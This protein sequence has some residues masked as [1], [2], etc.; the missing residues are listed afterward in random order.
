MATRKSTKKRALP[1]KSTAAAKSTAVAKPRAATRGLGAAGDPSKFLTEG[2]VTITIN[3]E[4]FTLRGTVGA[5]LNVQYHKDLEHAA[6]LGTIPDMVAAIASGFGLAD[7]DDFKQKLQD[8]IAALGQVPGLGPV[9]KIL[10]EGQ[11]KVTDLGIDTASGKYQFGFGV[12]LSDF[13]YGGISLDA[14]GL[15]F[16]YHKP[17]EAA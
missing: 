9:A 5:S 2:F 12:E 16:T 15:V 6:P 14:F 3:K 4:P 11:V 13:K 10:N 8:T 17:A 7:G 1:A